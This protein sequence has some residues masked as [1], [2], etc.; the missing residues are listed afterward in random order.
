MLCKGDAVTIF[1]KGHWC[2]TIEEI[3]EADPFEPYNL[4]LY[5]VRFDGFFGVRPPQPTVTVR[6]ADLKLII[7]S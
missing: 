2:G 5:V 4:K 7:S 1:W 3:I 6:E